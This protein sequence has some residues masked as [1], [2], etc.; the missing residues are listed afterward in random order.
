MTNFYIFEFLIAPLVLLV[1]SIQV[2][3]VTLLSE[4]IT[5]QP[6]IDEMCCASFLLHTHTTH[7]SLDTQCKNMEFAYTGLLKCFLLKNIP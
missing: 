1:R 7:N 6:L 2:I 4:N 5:C 3:V